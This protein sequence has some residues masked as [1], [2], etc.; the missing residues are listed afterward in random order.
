M[1][2]HGED[3]PI[4]RAAAALDDSAPRDPVAGRPP[5]ADAP[6][7]DEVFRR[8][9]EQCPIPIAVHRS[10]RIVFANAAAARLLRAPSAAELAGRTVAELSDPEY[11][12]A[13]LERTR[14]V[15]HEGTPAASLEQ[16]L[17]RLDG[18][19]VLVR[20]SSVPYVLGG[21][22][23]VV[24]IAEDVTARDR[25]AELRTLLATA[26]ETS[27]EA[28]VLVR[29]RDGRIVEANRAWS[30][31]AGMDHG[32]CVGREIGAL[33]AIAQPDELTRLLAE[34]RSG[35]GVRSGSLTLHP[36]GGLRR[37]LQVAAERVTVAD[38]PHMLAYGSDVTELRALERQQREAE[39][40]SALG[41]VA[42]GIAHDFNNLLT[43]ISSFAQL[44]EEDLTDADAVHLALR[45]IHRASI[46]AAELTHALLSFSRAAQS[47]RALLDLNALIV[48]ISRM[49]GRVIGADV[50]L[51]VDAAEEP[52]VVRANAGELEQV[53]VN[54]VVNARDAM[55]HGG[56][57]LLRSRSLTIDSAASGARN[58]FVLPPGRYVLLEVH[59][60]GTGIPAE[61]RPHLFEP[62]FTTK[63]PGEGTGL[64]LPTSY[65]IVQQHG[66]HIWFETSAGAGT[67]FFVALPDAGED[68][69]PPGPRAPTPLA[70]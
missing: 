61:A 52:A 70:S 17:Q 8:I 3:G 22:P 41:R 59:D 60:E 9:V 1:K 44:A 50:R 69:G 2:L 54:L 32:E 46:R 24:T 25:A 29:L 68:H 40:M 11:L 10:G 14:R 45:E 20:L 16:R 33:S 48:R 65:G 23:A 47:E 57:V 19:S 35:H 38:E 5:L 51:V 27:R 43:V 39:K 55:P 18:T 28:I 63:A 62:F 21:E 6:A 36:P 31:L 58:G 12:D 26:L 37:A 30:R 64:G 7:T 42:G 56:T 15:Q 34:V 66:G 67:T 13:A 4:T 49:L 53:V